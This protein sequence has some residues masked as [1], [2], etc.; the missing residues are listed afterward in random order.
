[1]SEVTYFYIWKK[2]TFPKKGLC[3]HFVRECRTEPAVGLVV[4][5]AGLVC[6]RPLY[7]LC[8]QCYHPTVC[9]ST[10]A[11]PVSL[12]RCI[13]ASRPSLS[14]AAS[15]W[16]HHRTRCGGRVPLPFPSTAALFFMH[17]CMVQ[18]TPSRALRALCVCA[19]NDSHA[20][21]AYVLLVWGDCIGHSVIATHP[22]M[23]LYFRDSCRLKVGVC[24]YSVCSLALL[25]PCTERSNSWGRGRAALQRVWNVKIR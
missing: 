24:S 18:C 12:G 3:G 20:C 13:H 23:S 17:P 9:K 8:W 10:A 15:W 25:A 2:I 11:R 5:S 22:D 1:L 7:I 4:G 19:A 6:S 21:L 16:G 14:S